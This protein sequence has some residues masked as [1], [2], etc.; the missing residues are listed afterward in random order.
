MTERIIDFLDALVSTVGAVDRRYCLVEK[1][2]DVN[3]TNI[4]YKYKGNGNYEAVNVDGGSVSYFRIVNSISFDVVDGNKAVKNLQATYPIRYVAMVRRDDINPLTFSQDV[5]NV[6]EG[7]NKDLQTQLQ[8]KNVNITVGSIDTDTTNIWGDEFTMPLSE[9][10]Y[11]RSM[12]MIDLTVTVIAAR[13]CWESCDDFPDILQGFDWCDPSTY[14]RLTPAQIE[15]L[16]GFL[17][18]SCADATV[19]NSDAS[20]STTVASG[21]TLVLPNIDFTDSDGTT[22][23]VPS[24]QNIVATPIPP[25]ADA[26]VQLN[27][28]TVGTVASGATDSFT[29]NLNGLPSGVWDGTAWQVTSAPC[30]DATIELN[31]VEMTTIPSGDTENI[32]IRQSSGATEVGSKQGVHWRIDD[33]AISINGSPVADVKAEDPLD[34]DVT[35]DGSP[36]GSWNGSAWIVPHCAAASIAITYSNNTPTYGDTITITATPTDITPTSYTFIIAGNIDETITVQVGNTLSWV[37]NT[38]NP[39]IY[40]QATDG[41][42]F[43]A[44]VDS[45]LTV[46]SITEAGTFITALETQT[47]DT[48]GARQK[49]AVNRLVWMLKGNDTTN[50]TDL[51]TSFSGTNNVMYIYCPTTDS[52]ASFDGYK[53]NLLNPTFFG[54]FVNMVAGDINKEGIVG[55]S[56][57][58]LN[59]NVQP[60]D[61][62]AQDAMYHCYQPNYDR[63]SSFAF[64][65][66][67]TVVSSAVVAVAANFWSGININC[68]LNSANGGGNAPRRAFNGIL[69]IGRNNTTRIIG[70]DNGIISGDTSDPYDGI[71]SLDV[72]AHAAHLGSTGL[73][74]NECP[75]RLAGF[76][77]TQY[78]NDSEYLDFCEAWFEFNKIVIPQG[79]YAQTG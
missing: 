64:G 70:A 22:T 62:G 33:S 71:F 79:R 73:P 77:V 39:T 28:T 21:A 26:T 2:A 47:S 36:V 25:C 27:G 69:T 74:T 41:S 14:Q 46:S 43:A 31:G 18:G 8:A 78:L 30:D 37:V 68:R 44:S 49:D 75:I 35:Q 51:W 59:M 5:A 40:V 11:T 50:S 56:G 55:G 67:E 7:R 53:I 32:S 3:G 54:T 23:S 24:V 42:S 29:V 63:Q 66:W 72:Y 48:M 6:L 9:P 61:F 45:L 58:Y 60:T 13:S 65:V 12:V 20:Y 38:L 19:E 10:N 76:A 1:R 4:P 57:K 52:T 15:C 16:E 17:C 34:I